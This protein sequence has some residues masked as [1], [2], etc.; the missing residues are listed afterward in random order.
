MLKRFKF[1][2]TYSESDQVYDILQELDI[3]FNWIYTNYSELV[4]IH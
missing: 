2:V 3:I 1:Y 4:I